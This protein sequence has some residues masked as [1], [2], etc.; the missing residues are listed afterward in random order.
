MGLAS[1]SSRQVRGGDRWPGLRNSPGSAGLLGERGSAPA[2]SIPAIMLL[3]AH[4]VQQTE[5]PH[6][7]G[8]S[9]PNGVRNFI[10]SRL[11]FGEL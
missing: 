4:P 5:I 1:V 8:L 6:L 2:F 9:M 11:P 7:E 10:F 3:F